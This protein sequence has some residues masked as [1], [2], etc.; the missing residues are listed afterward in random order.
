M[1]CTEAWFMKELNV[2][3]WA[4]QQP[5]MSGTWQLKLNIKRQIL[6]TTKSSHREWTYQKTSMAHA[7]ERLIGQNDTGDLSGSHIISWLKYTEVG[8][9]RPKSSWRQRW[10]ANMHLL[11]CGDLVAPV[12][13]SDFGSENTGAQQLYCCFSQ[14]EI[15]I[16]NLYF[17]SSVRKNKLSHITLNLS[18]AVLYLWKSGCGLMAF[19]TLLCRT[20]KL[21]SSSQEN[22]YITYSP[23][24]T[25]PHSVEYQ[26][27]VSLFTRFSIWKE[28]LCC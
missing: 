20:A 21:H 8:H 18:N 4:S 14:T 12:W 6:R 26:L 22:Q 25:C 9:Q 7:L 24:S 23:F 2:V 5:S 15:G 27:T 19:E 28:L 1:P 13:L 10:K 17:L 16:I 11:T 3:D